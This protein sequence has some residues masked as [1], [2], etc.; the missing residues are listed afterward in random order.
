MREIAYQRPAAKAMKRL[1]RDMQRRVRAALERFAET[2]HGDVK[3]IVGVEGL[4]RL[5]VGD[6]RVFLRLPPGRIDVLDVKPR[7]GAY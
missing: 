7:G 5:R 6:W 2:G 4:Y 1:P 3:A